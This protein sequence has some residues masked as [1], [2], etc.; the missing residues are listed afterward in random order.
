MLEKRIRKFIRINR[1]NNDI[2]FIDIALLFEMGW[3]RY[4]DYTILADVD[5]DIQKNRVMNRDGIS[6]D[7]FEKIDSIQMSQD[8]KRKLVDFI[9]NTDVNKNE[10]RIKIIN[11]LEELGY[12]A[13]Y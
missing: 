8:E 4:C 1:Y 5:K 12:N 7:D 11:I 6:E 10:L 9:I 3:D 13:K 2:I